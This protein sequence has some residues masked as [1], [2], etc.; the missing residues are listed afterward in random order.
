[1]RSHSTLTITWLSPDL[2]AEAWEFTHHPAKQPFYQRHALCWN[3]LLAAS[4][5]GALIPWPRSPHL[6]GVLVDQGYTDYADY[7]KYLARAKRGYRLNY[8]RLEE[9]LQRDGS[10]QLPAPIVLLCGGEALLFSGYRRL[11]LAWNY[12]MT[13]HVWRVSI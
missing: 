5:G 8:S 11:C 10:L 13:P 7:Q 4:S 3:A 12:G 1:M 6:E 9:A 2:A